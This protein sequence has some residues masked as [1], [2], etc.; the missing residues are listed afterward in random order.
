MAFYPTCKPQ[1]FKNFDYTYSAICP[2]CVESPRE[3]FKLCSRK[4]QMKFCN[5]KPHLIVEGNRIIGDVLKCIKCD[6]IVHDKILMVCD[7]LD[8]RENCSCQTVFPELGEFLCEDHINTSILYEE[9]PCNFEK[10]GNYYLCT[11]C[12]AVVTPETF[13]KLK[14]S[15]TTITCRSSPHASNYYE[16]F[17]RKIAV[18]QNQVEAFNR[19]VFLV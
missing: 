1:L 15:G 14:K 6:I 18:L 13:Y 2:Y 17:I 5:F 7:P 9:R 10:E 4:L 11:K 8:E 3:S 19:L 12:P 16:Y